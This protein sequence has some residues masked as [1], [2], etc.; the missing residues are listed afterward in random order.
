MGTKWV[1][2]LLLL[3]HR[4]IWDPVQYLQWRF[5]A[6]IVKGL[7]SLTIFTKNL[8]RRHWTGF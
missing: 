7:E 6:K 4:R 3:V 5:F 1:N 2:G 8:H